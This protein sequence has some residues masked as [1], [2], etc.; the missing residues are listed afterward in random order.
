MTIGRLEPE[1]GSVALIDNGGFGY[2]G[3][4]RPRT[5]GWPRWAPIAAGVWAAI[6]T[7]LGVYWATGR[8]GFPF[9]LE[10]DTAADVSIL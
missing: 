7:G 2:V 5:S 6:Y 3:R 9:G 1:V 8:P 4:V 10:A